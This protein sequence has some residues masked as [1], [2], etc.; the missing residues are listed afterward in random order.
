MIINISG[1]S[2]PFKFNR[3][4]LKP[5]KNYN[6]RLLDLH[7]IFTSKADAGIYKICTN[8]IDRENGNS[9]RILAYVRLDRKQTYLDLT[10]THGIWYKLRLHE[11][12]S[13]DVKLKSIARDEEIFFSEF[14]CQFEIKENV[15]L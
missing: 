1:S 2:A 7:A 12:S 11:L 6:I 8:I 9:D 3:V 15:R 4:E 13:S 14:S 5:F 10:P